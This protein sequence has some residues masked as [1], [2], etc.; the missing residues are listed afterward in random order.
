MPSGVGR[1]FGVGERGNTTHRGTFAQRS[2]VIAPISHLTPDFFFTGTALVVDQMAGL[3]CFQCNSLT[4]AN[5][6]RAFLGIAERQRYW[7]A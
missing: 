3:A 6:E 7:L 2:T 5:A 1:I 4:N